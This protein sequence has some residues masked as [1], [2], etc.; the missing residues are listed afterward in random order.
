MK[1]TTLQGHYA[2]FAS[3]TVALVIDLAAISVVLVAINWFMASVLGLLNIQAADCAARV[4]RGE[5]ALDFCTIYSVT[6]L[7]LTVAFAPVYF[8]FFW[9]IADGTTPGHAV[10]GLRVVRTSGKPM[11]LHVSIVRFAGYIVCFMTLG[12]GFLWVLIDNQRQGWHDTLAGTCVLYIR[13]VQPD[14]ANLLK[15]RARIE[16]RTKFMASVEPEPACE[17]DPDGPLTPVS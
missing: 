4:A 12:L 5:A 17:P 13:E 2:G 1:M 3:R 15:W 14:E 11:R 16:R 8:I 10:M 9:L 6:S 7:L